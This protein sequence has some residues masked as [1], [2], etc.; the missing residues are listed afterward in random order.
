MFDEGFDVLIPRQVVE[1]LLGCWLGKIQ[2][3][4]EL[5]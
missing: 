5:L 3:S 2:G 4:N 1:K